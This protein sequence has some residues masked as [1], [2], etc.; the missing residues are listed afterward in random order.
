MC[1]CVC[2]CVCVCDCRNGRLTRYQQ[3]RCDTAQ[4][5][6]RSDF[7]VNTSFESYGVICCSPMTSYKG[8]AATFRTLLAEP[9]KG[10]NNRLNTT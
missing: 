10:P 6:I 8:T 4:N 9:S 1:V 2:V 5:I 3:L 7:A